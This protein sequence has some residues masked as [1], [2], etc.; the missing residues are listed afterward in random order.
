MNKKYIGNPLGFYNDLQD[1]R[2][3]ELQKFNQGGGPGWDKI[4]QK[5]SAWNTRRKNNKSQRKACRGG[6]K[7]SCTQKRDKHNSWGSSNWK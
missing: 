3:E 6:S 1:Q 2:R 4:K 5:Y 7:P